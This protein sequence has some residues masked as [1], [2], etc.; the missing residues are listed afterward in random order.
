MNDTKT[1]TMSLEAQHDIA[2]AFQG[3]VHAY[4]PVISPSDFYGIGVAV[5]NESGYMPISAWHYSANTY[6]E[7][8]REA[9]RLNSEILGMSPDEALRIIC[10]T[11]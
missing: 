6:E 8:S 5:A 7:A 4:V 9:D 3:K 10:S 2:E 11:M 1:K